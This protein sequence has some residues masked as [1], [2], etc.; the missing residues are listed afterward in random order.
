MLVTL[1]Q[2][3]FSSV[4]FIQLQ[5]LE[6][7]AVRPCA[8]DTFRS[9]CP[10]SQ[11]D[12]VMV[13]FLLPGILG[14]SCFRRL[15]VRFRNPLRIATVA[16]FFINQYSTGA[17]ACWPGPR[18]CAPARSLALCVADTWFICVTL[19]L[20]VVV[21]LSTLYAGTLLHSTDTAQTSLSAQIAKACHAGLALGVLLSIVV[22]IPMRSFSAFFPN[23]VGSRS[24]P[25]G[26]S[27][28]H[29][30]SWFADQAD[31]DDHS[32]EPVRHAADRGVRCGRAQGRARPREGAQAAGHG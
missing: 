15:F 13:A 8:F 7:D 20:G 11:V 27:C 24:L 17:C 28:S 23:Q 30:M 26:P 6:L 1:L 4:Y 16:C 5:K 21:L 29:S 14:I 3:F 18:H 19:G 2:L 12:I 10:D 9:A 22:R 31:S 25:F 32:A